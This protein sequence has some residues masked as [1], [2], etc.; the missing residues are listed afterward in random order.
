MDGLPR[1]MRQRSCQDLLG[2]RAVN[3][4]QAEVAA[5]LVEREL[6]V[7]DAEQLRHRRLQVVNV[8]LTFEYS[9]S[10]ATPRHATS[11]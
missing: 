3:V 6:C 8:D 4:G 5:D 1:D 11:G 2:H 7:V 9:V 10:H